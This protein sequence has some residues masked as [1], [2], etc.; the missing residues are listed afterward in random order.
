MISGQIAIL[1]IAMSWLSG[2]A[3]AGFEQG[4]VAACPPVVDCSREY[5]ARAAEE[6][7]MLQGG[8]AIVEMMGDFA[9]MRD[10]AR[11]CRG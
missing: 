7:T 6:L 9:V 5:Q 3:R 1:V 2:C 10:Q 11:V 8:S 4:D